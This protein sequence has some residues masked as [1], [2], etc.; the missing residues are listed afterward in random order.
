M[1]IIHNEKK[2]SGE[3]Y[4]SY[5]IAFKVSMLKLFADFMGQRMAAK[6]FSCE[7]SSL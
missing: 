5:R 4:S 7:I 1:Y 2:K 3:E 6:V